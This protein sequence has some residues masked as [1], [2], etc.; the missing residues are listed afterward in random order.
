M[1]KVGN[2]SSGN[3][4]HVTGPCHVCVK[5]EGN[6]IPARW[7]SST[8]KAKMVRICDDCYGELLGKKQ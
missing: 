2:K 1:A 6:F 8:G 5:E 4:G 3:S 7:H